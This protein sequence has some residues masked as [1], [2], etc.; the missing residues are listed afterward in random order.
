[1]RGSM[2]KPNR[3]FRKRSGSTRRSWALKIPIRLLASITWPSFTRIWA[4]TP[5]PNRSFSKRSE[6]VRR[7]GQKVTKRR[8]ASMTWD[9]CTTQWASTP[10]PNSSKA[11]RIYQKVLGPEHPSTVTSLDNLGVLYE[12]TGQYAKAEPLD[13][14]ALRIRQ[15]VLGSE[16]PSVVTSLNSLAILDFDRGR[17]NEATA[18]A[19][20]ASAA[21]L[22]ILSKIFAVHLRRTALG[23]LGHL[24][25]VWSF[26]YSNRNR[27]RLS[28]SRPT[29][30]RRGTGFHRRRSPAA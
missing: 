28:Q 27:D 23:L 24:S 7:I 1:M 13:L 9:C 15:K 11:L 21:E 10:R 22:T 17:I 30:Q 14:E 8:L 26:P 29:L 12:E 5:K 3:S 18:L 25:P 19:R 6:S 16:H 2:S 20:Q 4:S